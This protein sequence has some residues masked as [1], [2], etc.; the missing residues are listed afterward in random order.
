LEQEELDLQASEI[1]DTEFMDYSW[2]ISQGLGIDDFYL[3]S[4]NCI[5]DVKDLYFRFKEDIGNVTEYG[6]DIDMYFRIALTIGNVST[7]Y[8]YCYKNA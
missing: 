4:I 7:T 5:E 3:D 1:T 8:K 2:A 6:L